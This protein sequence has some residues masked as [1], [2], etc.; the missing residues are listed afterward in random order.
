MA[1]S[2]NQLHASS[3]ALLTYMQETATILG[4]LPEDAPLRETFRNDVHDLIAELEA[5][6]HAMDDETS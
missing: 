2:V 5:V 3:G 1:H 4:R 6:L